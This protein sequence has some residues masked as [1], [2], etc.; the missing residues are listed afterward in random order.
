[1][2]L[3]PGKNVSLFFPPGSRSRKVINAH[4]KALKYYEKTVCVM[5]FFS[6]MRT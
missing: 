6:E 3:L 2:V 5:N 1:M 4:F